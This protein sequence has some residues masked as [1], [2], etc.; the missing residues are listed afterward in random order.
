MSES[1]VRA[2]GPGRPRDPLLDLRITEAAARVFRERGWLES[3]MEQIAARAGVSKATL[4]RRYP[5]KASVA[6]ATW[7]GDRTDRFPEIDTGSV[8]GDLTAYILGTF[9]MSQRGGWLEILRGLIVEIPSDPSVAQAIAGVW[10]W[11]RGVVAD[12]LDRAAT[13]GEIRSNCESGPRER[14][15]RRANP[16]S[17][18]GDGGRRRRGVRRSA[19]RRRDERDR[20]RSLGHRSRV[21]LLTFFGASSA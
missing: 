3:T 18:V 8:W 4:Y 19:R 10:K 5:S 1:E 17:V 12:F 13:R 16:A 20:P 2:I 6:F 15:H 21:K 9:E 14:A 7:V 11:R